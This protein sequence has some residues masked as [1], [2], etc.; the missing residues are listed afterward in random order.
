MTGA[1]LVVDLQNGFCR[2][3]GSVPR[4]GLGLAGVDAAVAHAATA[5][6]AAREAG[7]PVVFT[8]HL[9]RPGR[10]DEGPNLRRDG[11]LAA[12]DGLLL[13][14]WDAEVVDDLGWTPADLTVDKCRFDAF[15]WTSLDPLL[16]G[17]GVDELAV[18]GV[19]TNICVEST[20]RAA[21]MRDYRVTLL[22]DACAAATPRLHEAGVEVMGECGFATVRT[23]AEHVAGAVPAVT[24]A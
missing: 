21:F 2:P 23:V 18:C 15:L 10:A 1:L 12:L 9:Y 14:T 7:T 13:G 24:G 4:V 22:A 11:A 8:R 3:E 20:V 5:V 19:V 6:H 17:L 16:R